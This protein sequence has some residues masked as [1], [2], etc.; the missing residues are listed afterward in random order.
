MDIYLKWRERCD[1]RRPAPGT[2]SLKRSRIFFAFTTIILAKF[3]QC[4]KLS[5]NSAE[6]IISNN[7]GI[8]F[9]EHFKIQITTKWPLAPC[10]FRVTG[11]GENSF[12][13]RIDISVQ[14]ERFIAI[15]ITTSSARKNVK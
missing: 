8:L 3:G 2:N 14:T 9:L 13:Q 10:L 1:T 12:F 6:E 5:R 15:R 11:I 4:L 7:G